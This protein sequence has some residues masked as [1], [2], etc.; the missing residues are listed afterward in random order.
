MHTQ[1]PARR[2]KPSAI[3]RLPT[4]APCEFPPTFPSCVDR[5]FRPGQST[6]NQL[7]IRRVSPI[8]EDFRPH[9][10]SELGAHLGHPAAGAGIDAESGI[11]FPHG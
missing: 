9:F 10:Q 3:I 8:E 5:K 1:R 2:F 4:P 11:D 7:A 6:P